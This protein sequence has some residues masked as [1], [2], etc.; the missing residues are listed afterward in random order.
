MSDLKQYFENT[1]GFG[2]LSTSSSSG[3]VN[4]AVYS[5]PHVMEDGTLA[6][7]MNDKL[8]HANVLENP[9]AHFL[10]R[11]KDAPGYKGKRISMTMIREEEDTE[12]LFELCRRCEVSEEEPT[13]RRFLVFFSVD[14]E[15]PLIGS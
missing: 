14:K 9:K 10:F 8:S 2:I 3:A 6:V 1:K 15:L 4:A 12:L 5:R 11:E 7:V 13:K